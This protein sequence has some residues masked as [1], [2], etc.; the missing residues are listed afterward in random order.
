MLYMLS[1]ARRADRFHWGR[2]SLDPLGWALVGAEATGIH[3]L[4]YPAPDLEDEPLSELRISRPDEVEQ[5]AAALA[6]RP[7][8]HYD[9]NAEELGSVGVSRR[10]YHPDQ[11]D[12]SLSGTKL[13]RADFERTVYDVLTP[14]YLTAASRGEATLHTLS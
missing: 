3:G 2:T 1:P 6:A 10:H 14:F 11:R 9:A 7:P 13:G 5:V 4:P 12:P 8:V